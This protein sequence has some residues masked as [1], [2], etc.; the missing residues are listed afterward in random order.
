[1]DSYTIFADMHESHSASMTLTSE[2]L[3]TQLAT[4]QMSRFW[5]SI[6]FLVE[7]VELVFP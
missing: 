4:P 2:T 5:D 3:P 1:M 6:W 7:L